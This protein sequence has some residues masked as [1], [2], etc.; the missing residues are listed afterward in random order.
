MS[1]ATLPAIISNVQLGVLGAVLNTACVAREQLLAL[2]LN[3]MSLALAKNRVRCHLLVSYIG[4]ITGVWKPFLCGP[5]YTTSGGYTLRLTV[6]HS[7][8]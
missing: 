6:G 3:T 2:P 7:H 4:E 5:P 1:S 8:A